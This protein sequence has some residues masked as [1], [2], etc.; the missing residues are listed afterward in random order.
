LETSEEVD[1]VTKIEVLECKNCKQNLSE[2]KG[3]ISNSRQVFDIPEKLIYVEEFQTE[4]KI[5][6]NC[7]CKNDSSFPKGVENKV[8][9]GNKVKSVVSYLSQYQLIPYERGTELFRDIFGKDISEGTI[10]NSNVELFK[11]LE[12]PE[13][14]IKELIIN[15]PVV[16]YD[17]TSLRVNNLNY[18]LHVS[19]TND[20]TFYAVDRHRNKEATDKI[21]ILPKFTGKAIHDNY[22]L[23][24][25]YNCTHGLCNAHHHRELK[26]AFQED[27]FIWS[28]QMSDLL[29]RIKSEVDKSTDTNALSTNKLSLFENEYSKILEDGLKNYPITEINLKKKGRKKQS[30]PKNLLDRFIK[31]R[32]EILLFMYDFTV[33]FDNNQ[34]E[35]DIRMPKLKQ[36]ISGCFRSEDGANI[37][38]RIR[39]YISTVKKQGINVL[40]SISNAFSEKPFMPTCE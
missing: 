9:Y 11:K 21:G 20:L 8:Q 24:F 35:R 22:A 28:S 32:E 14:F 23:Y 15:S 17:E 18:W 6:S 1:K 16:N 3:T 4:V 34:A 12:K 25:Q 36:K 26:G 29:F 2:I 5:C 37:F 27:G 13:E 39:G 31:R 30:K 40:E 19:C 10:Y 7:G 33:P 38:A